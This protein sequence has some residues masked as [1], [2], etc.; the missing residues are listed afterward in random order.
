MMPMGL[1]KLHLPCVRLC[2][3]SLA[4]P[5]KAAKPVFA[6]GLVQASECWLKHPDHEHYCRFAEDSS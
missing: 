3:V 6:S 4:G 2:F 1:L 5:Q